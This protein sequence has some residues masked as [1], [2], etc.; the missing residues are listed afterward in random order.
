MAGRSVVRRQVDTLVVETKQR[1]GLVARVTGLLWALELVDVFLL[2]SRLD[3]FGVAPRSVNGLLGI[4]AAPFLHGGLG[5][6]I[7]NTIPL[8]VLG[9][10][11]TSRK[12]MDFWVVALASTVVGGLGTWLI[13]PAATVHIGASGV[14]FGLLGFLMGRG[15]FER[16]LGAIAMS[17]L[18]TF[19]FGGMLWGVLPVVA[20]A[21]ISWQMH[22]FGY[23]G[24]L[25]VSWRLG[26]GLRK[27]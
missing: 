27:R 24:G 1:V 6:L 13:A 18:V 26:K 12:K 19:L 25:L 3:A 11:A 20:G 16:K 8:L 14:I 15:I 5:H 7:A 10:L 22:L 2:G 21:G 23:L 9:F 17:M 4:F